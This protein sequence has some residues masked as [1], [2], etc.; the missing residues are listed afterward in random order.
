MQQQRANLALNNTYFSTWLARSPNPA[1]KRRRN[2][3]EVVDCHCRNR[4]TR[5]AATSEKCGRRTPQSRDTENC[6]CRNSWPERR[7]NA[8]GT[9]IRRPRQESVTK[10]RTREK[11]DNRDRWQHEDVLDSSIYK[12]APVPGGVASGQ[13]YQNVHNFVSMSLFTRKS[14]TVTSC[15]VQWTQDARQRR[16]LLQ[17][18][19]RRRP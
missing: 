17:L 5:D 15:A 9:T 8:S 14:G 3:F 12:T 10:C 6:R 13:T 18:I 11:G 7:R 2:V 1:N 4:C 19:S 16:R